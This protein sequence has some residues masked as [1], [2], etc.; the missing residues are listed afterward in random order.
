VL[1]YVSQ[2]LFPPP[3][4]MPQEPHLV[5]NILHL[6][7]CSI[8]LATAASLHEIGMLSFK[9]ASGMCVSTTIRA[10]LAGKL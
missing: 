1:A 2:L 6:P 5:N 8:G 10:A 9:S 7:G 3:Q 4:L